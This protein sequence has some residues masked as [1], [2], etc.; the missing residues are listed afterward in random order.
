MPIVPTN[1]SVGTRFPEALDLADR[2]LLADSIELAETAKLFEFHCSGCH[3][4]GGNIVR[5]GKTLKLKALKKYQMDSVEAIAEIITQGRGNMSAYQ[6]RLTPAQI[7]AL[8]G[9]VL[10]QAQQDWPD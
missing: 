7:Q 1:R 9:Y 10:E 6:D 8:A 2:A 5:R 4:H 3:I